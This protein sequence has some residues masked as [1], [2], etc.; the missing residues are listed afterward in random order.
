[1]TMTRCWS[2]EKPKW[3]E[4]QPY[5]GATVSALTNKLAR[6]CTKSLS[7]LS[8]ELAWNKPV[9][10]L[11]V[12]VSLGRKKRWSNLLLTPNRAYPSSTQRAFN[13]R[14]KMKL[15]GL[16]CWELTLS[17]EVSP[18]TVRAQSRSKAVPNKSDSFRRRFSLLPHSMLTTV[19]I[20]FIL[21]FIPDKP[22]L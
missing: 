17:T 22:Q 14:K 9:I 20:F 11:L 18:K 13:Q 21:T 2:L 16:R 7:N 12:K 1:M 19:S 5:S 8:T 3:L 10:K 6:S 4:A 15:L